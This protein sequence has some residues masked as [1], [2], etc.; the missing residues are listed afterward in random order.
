[1]KLAVVL[2][3]LAGSLGAQQWGDLPAGWNYGE[4]AGVEVDRRGHVWVF[5]RG[6]HPLIEFDARGTFLR[7][8][9]DDMVT[10]SHT[11]R[12]DH[13]GFLWVVDV[14]GHVVLKL[15]PQ[16][17]VVMVLGRKGSAGTTKDRFNQ[18][19]DVAVTPA[20]EI[21]V[22]DGYGNM[23][24]VKFSKEGKYLLEWGKKGTGPGE[25]Q[26]VHAVVTDAKGRV[27]VSDR[28][29]NRIQ[30]F[31]PNGKYLTEWKGIGAFSGLEMMPDGRLYA[32][33]GSRVVVLNLEGRVV[34]T[35]KGDVRAAH[36]VAVGP[37]GEVFVGELNW[38]L[39]K[40]TSAR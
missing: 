17:R 29:N 8:L 25:F 7:S 38:R 36:A 21:Y 37:N 39:Q 11:V 10:R 26:L 24:V 22:A 19:A 12:V 18:P 1:M 34:E 23:R 32:A 5:H 31:D 16:G 13:E 28:T 14:G 40:L 27:Y 9:L 6:P 30:V 4:V 33:G 3:L 15:N 20:G 2:G 35:L